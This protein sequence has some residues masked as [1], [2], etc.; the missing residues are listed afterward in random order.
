MGSEESEG[1]SGS[2]AERRREERKKEKKV[3]QKSSSRSKESTGK[4]KK[5]TKIAG[6]PKKALSAFFLWLN[7]NREQIRKDHPELALTDQTKKAGEIWREMEDKSEWNAKADEDKKRYEK[8][9]EKWKAEGGEEKLKE[10]KRQEKES[11]GSKKS[12]KT[13]SSKKKESSAVPA[14]KIKS[15]EFIDAED[16]SSD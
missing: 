16:D 3:K 10:A 7:E 13:D 6:Q 12:K 9:Y 15:K 4:S 11:G 1:E 8:E 2:D 5:L 14:D